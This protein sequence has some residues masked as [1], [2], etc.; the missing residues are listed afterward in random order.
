M[1]KKIL[2]FTVLLSLFSCG[3]QVIYRDEESHISYETDL[4]AI[5]IK[6]NR[7]EISQKLKNNLYDL[8]NPNQLNI[9]AKYFLSLEI[10]LNSSPT[11]ITVTGASGRN[12][13]TLKVFYKLQNLNSAQTISSGSTTVNDNYNVT[14]NRY[15]TSVNENFVS[16]NLT[17]LAAQSLR[18]SLV[19]D[20][21]EIKKECAEKK[22]DKYFTCP[23]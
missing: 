12:N 4:A 3:F 23:L 6:K 18:N 20:F 22:D 11:F 10:K 16:K 13:I 14:E 9:E 19:N 8:L 21:I 15:A 5:R 2:I 17:K 7:D 1:L